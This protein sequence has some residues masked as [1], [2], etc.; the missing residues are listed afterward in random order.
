M[1]KDKSVV[2]SYG[3]YVITKI[4][5]Q[6]AQAEQEDTEDIDTIQLVW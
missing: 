2:M 1:T 6:W 4:E 3:N 5:N